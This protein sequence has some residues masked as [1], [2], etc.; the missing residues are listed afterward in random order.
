MTNLLLS[1]I[2]MLAGAVAALI[3]GGK[4][5]WASAAAALSVGS[6]CLVAIK[7]VLAALAGRPPGPLSVA[8]SIPWGRFSIGLDGL[9]AFFFLP[10]LVL[11]PLAAVY[12]YAYLDKTQGRVGHSWFF[13]NLLIISMMMLLAARDGILFL[14]AWEIMAVSSFL[15][16]ITDHR[17]AAVRNAG[18]TYLVAT[19]IGTAALLVFF[20]L[21]GGRANSFDFQR[22]SSLGG[23]PTGPATGLFVLALA[24]FGSKA[25]HFPLHVWL[26]EAHPAAPSHVSALMSAVMIKIG[27]YGL[28][29]ALTFLGPVQAA[30]GWALVALGLVS[31]I[32][33]VA[34]ALAQNDIK[35][36]LA[37]SSIENMG[38]MLLGIGAGLLGIC[39]RIPALA[40]LGLGGGL[41][42][43]LNHAV[44]K[45][46]LFLGAGSV[47]HATGTRQ[48]DR[49]GGLFKPMP[50]TGF[51]FIVGAAAIA[52]LPPFN[53]FVSELLI[54]YAGVMAAL[55]E[56]TQAVALAIGILGGMALIGGLVAV[57]FLKC[58]G[59]VF[60]GETRHP[61][62]GT[63]HE[64]AG[65]MRWAM[66]LLAGLCLV[67]GLAAPWMLSLVVPAIQVVAGNAQDTVFR[68]FPAAAGVILTKA[69]WMGVLF[70][71][72][73]GALYWIRRNLACRRAGG[74]AGVETWD[75]GFARPSARMQ[76]TASSFTQPLTDFLH[77][78]LGARNKGPTVRGYFP[79]SAGF[80]IRTPDPAR[81]WL[82]AP[83]FRFIA[84]RLSP[85]LALQ[86]GR[87]HLYVLYMALILIVL[88]VWKG[89]V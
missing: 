11:S 42:H 31:G 81:Q 26:P 12:G 71:F 46:L 69:A 23:I 43:V 28:L 14:L 74:E 80:V 13:F 78:C 8:W 53:G 84:R 59:L 50:W 36:L 62:T 25:G 56:T 20:A 18:W 68:S 1:V 35:R 82:F 73:A 54:Y 39:W 66:L 27:L 24:G 60:L 83:L 4:N 6:G 7:P 89:G 33:G 64:A 77:A 55:S 34:L 65:P 10:L 41:L 70:I 67:M 15:L 88:L 16:V 58:A 85:L 37:Y 47:L 75:C 5:R 40:L 72:T 2:I 21:L 3:V 49:L 79:E 86:H 29:R 9:S 63:V 51:A 32:F 48:M 44:F 17:H 76:Y 30:W 22:F 87:I 52:A 61:L 19:H 57:G 38:I 45:G